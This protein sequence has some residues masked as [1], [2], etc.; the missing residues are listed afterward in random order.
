LVS[1]WAWQ[2]I[3]PDWTATRRRMNVLQG[4]G[5]GGTVVDVC[6]GF[7]AGSSALLRD[8]MPTSENQSSAPVPSLRDPDDP[9]GWHDL[10][11]AEGVSYMRARR[12]DV[13]EGD[14]IAID[15][16][17]QDSAVGP[18]NGQRYGVH[19][20]RVRATASP[21]DLA[22]LTIDVV[23]HLLPYPECPG[24]LAAAQR[25]RGRSLAD[26]RKQVGREIRGADSC[27]HLTDVLRSLADVPTLV[28]ALR[29][30]STN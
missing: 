25:M 26:F 14:V 15:I 30:S 29:Q 23:G 24:A 21:D 22:L 11:E 10:T 3:D 20:Y 4:L 28:Q 27:T 16:G 7:R 5:K 18:D 17:F 2:R 6:S 8:G 19:E 1:T 12:M 9:E 13:T